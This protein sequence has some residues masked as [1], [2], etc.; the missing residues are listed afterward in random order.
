M[1]RTLI[2]LLLLCFGPVIV[3]GQVRPK[4]TSPPSP[5]LPPPPP[6]SP[7]VGAGN[8]GFRLLK[9]PVAGNYY[10]GMT[11]SEYDSVARIS[12]L[13][14]KTGKSE[15]WVTPGA[16]FYGRRLWTLSL[17]IDSIFTA[18][19]ADIMEMYVTKL[20]EPDWKETRDTAW[21]LPDT[22]D[23]SVNTGYAV[24]Q[25]SLAWNFQYHDIF[26]TVILVDLRNGKWRS[27]HT[28]RYAGN[29]VFRGMLS[30]LEEREGY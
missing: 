4:T 9:I 21:Q 16:L 22:N 1:K 19:P 26:I 29:S 3:N 7:T 28:I 5:S 10:L 15:Y 2:L 23:P 24:K 27:V 6:P 14:L 13:T 17:S 30:S 20:G 18:P 8:T 11:R 25:S 12:P